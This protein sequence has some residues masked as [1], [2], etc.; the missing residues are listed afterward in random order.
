MTATNPNSGTST[1]VTLPITVADSNHLPDSTHTIRTQGTLTFG[2]KTDSL[3]LQTII[4]LQSPFPAGGAVLDF[5]LNGIHRT[6]T[7]DAHGRAGTPGNSA[8]LR[9]YKFPGNGI[10]VAKISIKLIGSLKPSAIQGVSINADGLPVKL[11]AAFTIS[12]RTYTDIPSLTF[13]RTKTSVSARFGFKLPYD[14]PP[15][16]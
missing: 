11:L 14:L 15:T 12:G 6:V 5:L 13:T 2:A 9:E 10:P 4:P 16:P 8:I 7:F 3:V 1:T